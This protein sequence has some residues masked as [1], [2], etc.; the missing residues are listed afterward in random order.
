M[1][2]CKRCKG[3]MFIDRRYTSMIHLEIYCIICGYR[4]FFNPP[5]NSS[6]GRWLLKK[7]VSRAKDTMSLM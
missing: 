6:E 7:E 2:F 1:I 4:K 3:R 5:E